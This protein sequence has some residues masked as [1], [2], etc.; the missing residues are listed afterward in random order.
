MVQNTLF[1]PVSARRRF[2]AVRVPVAV[3]SVVAIFELVALEIV[4][5]VNTAFV[6]FTV[7][8]AIFPVE[9]M[10]VT[11]VDARVED[12]V[13]RKFA[14]VP[15]P[16]SVVDAAKIPPETVEFPFTA[17]LPLTVIFPSVVEARVEEPV[18]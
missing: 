12:P 15:V 8:P 14:M 13:T 7:W 3:R 5:F 2:C 17:W 16:V 18:A 6:P 11:V 9:V 10:F 4:A 1:A